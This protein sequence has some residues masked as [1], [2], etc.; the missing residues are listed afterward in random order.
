MIN[1][2]A[3]FLSDLHRRVELLARVLNGENRSKTDFCAL[4]SVEEITINRDLRY[5][6]EL[7]INISSRKNAVTLFSPVR[8]EILLELCSV[9]LPLKLNSSLIEK[10]IIPLAKR[11]PDIYFQRLVLL[12]EAIADCKTVFVKYGPGKKGL[13]EEYILEP[14]RLMAVDKNWVLL[15]NKQIETKL[16]TFYISRISSISVTGNT[17]S[18]KELVEEYGKVF[19]MV[20]KF[21]R[22]VESEILDKIW[23]DEFDLDTSNEDYILLTTHQ[24]ITNHLSAWCISW[25]DQMEIIEPK[26][27]LTNINS[28]IV[29]YIS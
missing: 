14:R 6:R 10:Q 1:I 15:A 3:T 5:L 27:L 11:F 20:F 21:K 22:T 7:G 17:F 24:P 8:P 19:R 18:Q 28:M 12:S 9:Y 26:E 13:S 2:K 23:F 29:D 16:Q 4:F 25:W